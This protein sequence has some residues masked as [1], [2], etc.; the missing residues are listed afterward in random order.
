MLI[1]SWTW[2]WFY[3]LSTYHCF[4]FV[5]IVINSHDRNFCQHVLWLYS[6]EKM[7]AITWSQ[8]SL[9]MQIQKNHVETKIIM[10][11]DDSYQER[12]IFFF[13]QNR[14]YSVLLGPI[15]ICNDFDD[16]K[17]KAFSF[18]FFSCSA[19]LTDKEFPFFTLNAT[20][21]THLSFK[22]LVN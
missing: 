18:I 5:Q 22:C 11:V 16:L 21:C 3:I 1:L 19:I 13:N 10:A 17:R 14:K 9:K 20:V 8:L 4:L 2:S 15:F 7:H 12:L 6:V